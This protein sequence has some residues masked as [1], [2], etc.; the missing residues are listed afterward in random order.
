MK[1]QVAP[2]RVGQSAHAGTRAAGVGGVGRERGGG[3]ASLAAHQINTG[4][5]EAGGNPVSMF[6]GTTT[7]RDNLA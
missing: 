7:R 5:K 4:V 1:A 6:R 2:W 3:G